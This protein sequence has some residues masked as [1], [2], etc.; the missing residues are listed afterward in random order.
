[1]GV[2]VRRIVPG[3][4][5][6]R[7]GIEAGDILLSLDAARIGSVEAFL[8]TVRLHH[9]GDAVTVTVLRAG[10]RHEIVATLTGLPLE[11]DPDF[12]VI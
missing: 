2:S 8:Q 1:L 3:S 12:N 7:A 11:T 9:A 5:A 4:A 6:E 10:E